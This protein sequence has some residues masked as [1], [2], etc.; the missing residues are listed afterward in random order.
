MGTQRFFGT[1]TFGRLVCRSIN[2][3]AQTF[4]RLSSVLGLLGVV[5][6]MTGQE[7]L[8]IFGIVSELGFRKYLANALFNNN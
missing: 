8:T 5:L 1:I 6:I 7:Y 4:F 3:N 2:I